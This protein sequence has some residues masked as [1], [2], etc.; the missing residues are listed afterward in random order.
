ML[1]FKVIDNFFEDDVCEEICNS[2]QSA[3]FPLYYCN[4]VSLKHRKD[5]YYFT[6][7]LVNNSVSV[8]GFN[9]IA[10]HFLDQISPSYVYRIQVNAYPKEPDHNLH[11]FHIDLDHTHKVALWYVNTNNGYTILKDPTSQE[12]V[13]IE[14]V[15]NRMLFFDGNIFH[16]SVTHTDTNL[17]HVVNMNYLPS[18]EIEDYFK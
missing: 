4:A 15:K 1:N 10:N 12:D 11:G 3:S 8:S 16:S 14:S 18:I 9:N 17:R 7:M 13:R 2:I 5:H 6:H